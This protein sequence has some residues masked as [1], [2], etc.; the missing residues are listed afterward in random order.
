MSDLNEALEAL[1]FRVA[2]PGSGGV[3]LS[4]EQART[5]LEHFRRPPMRFMG[6]VESM[7]PKDRSEVR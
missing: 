4:R 5:I 2:R 6:P 7:T 1:R 3:V